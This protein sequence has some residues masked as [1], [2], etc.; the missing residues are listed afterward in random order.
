MFSMPPELAA[1]VDP[2]TGEV[3]LRAA[4]LTVRIGGGGSTN[5]LEGSLTVDSPAGVKSV[6]S[7]APPSQGAF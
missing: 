1:A 2:E 4:R 7:E 5:A 6:V 3:A